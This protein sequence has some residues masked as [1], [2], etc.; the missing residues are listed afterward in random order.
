VVP[1]EQAVGSI[2]SSLFDDAS[3]GY[4]IMSLNPID[5]PLAVRAGAVLKVYSE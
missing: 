5:D 3:R 4:E 2:A 1:F